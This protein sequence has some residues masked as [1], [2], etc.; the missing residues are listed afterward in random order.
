MRSITI[1]TY[2][3]LDPSGSVVSVQ[4]D[5]FSSQMASLAAIHHRC[6]SLQE[7]L[8]FRQAHQNWPPNSTILTFDDG[9]RNLYDYAL[10]VLN[11]LKFRAT[12]FVITGHIGGY[13][14]W[15]KLPPGMQRKEMLSWEQIVALQD[16]GIEIG[17]HTDCHPDLRRIDAAQMDHELSESREQLED[18]LKRQVRTFA[19]P[20]GSLNR[21][22]VTAAASYFQAACTT[23]LRRASE[24]PLHR[25]PRVDMYYF[26]NCNDLRPVVHGSLDSL[27]LCRRWARRLKELLAN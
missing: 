20:F 13:N 22:V 3:S 15:S 10:P 27:L 17:A 4:P 7:A 19:Y 24:H 8:D 5:M 12:V 25:L 1:L 14:D 16:A 6:I 9:Y 11:E 23:E 2:H 18:R 21:T 26:R